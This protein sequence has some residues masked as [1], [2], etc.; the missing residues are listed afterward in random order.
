M[1]NDQWHSHMREATR[2]TSE[3]NLTE[4]TGVLQR[5]RSGAVQ[6][7]F[8]PPAVVNRAPAGPA[9]IMSRAVV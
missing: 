6:P 8:A 2:L 4:A 9:M 3:G 5:L 7:A 1:M